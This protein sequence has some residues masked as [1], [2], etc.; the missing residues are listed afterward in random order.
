MLKRKRKFR[1]RVQ[2]EEYWYLNA[3]ARMSKL[4]GDSAQASPTRSERCAGK[5]WWTCGAG[6]NYVGFKNN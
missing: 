2:D 6:L 5:R 1:F 4:S 3:K